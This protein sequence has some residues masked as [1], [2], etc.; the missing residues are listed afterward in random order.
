[1][2]STPEDAEECVRGFRLMREGARNAQNRLASA[3]ASKGQSPRK[4]MVL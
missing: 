4:T 2:A 3:A 1:M